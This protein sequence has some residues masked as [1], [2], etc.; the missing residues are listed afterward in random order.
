[1]GHPGDFPSRAQSSGLAGA[2][3]RCVHTEGTRN[4]QRVRICRKDRE[5]GT[6]PADH[7]PERTLPPHQDQRDPLPL[8]PAGLMTH[9]DRMPPPHL[10]A[11]VPPSWKPLALR[12]LRLQESLQRTPMGTKIHLGGL[13]PARSW[14]NAAQCPQLCHIENCPPP[15]PQETSTIGS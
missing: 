7:L 8:A 14:L 12:T 4:E 2:D 10:S 3:G 15:S 11:S 1:M 13:T 5:P 6:R 9:C